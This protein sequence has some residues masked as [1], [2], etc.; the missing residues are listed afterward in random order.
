MARTSWSRYSNRSFYLFV[1][2]WVLG[3]VLLTVVPLG[4]AFG[5]SLTNFDGSSPR[6][7]WIGFR[8]YTEL[9]GDSEAWHALLRTIAY[10]AIAVPLSVA[11]ALGLA[12]LLN[13]RLKA[14]RSVADDLLPA[15]GGSGGGDGDHVEARPEPGRRHR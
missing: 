2:P 8:N 15:V 14:A 9:F 3:F 7:R 1:S 4:Y 5:M 10:T 11:A 12:V 13:R 6:W